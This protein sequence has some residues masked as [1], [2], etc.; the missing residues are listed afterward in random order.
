MKGRDLDFPVVMIFYREKE[1][2]KAEEEKR[3]KVKAVLSCE[4][5]AVS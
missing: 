1:D 2:R 5:P 4:S 3:L